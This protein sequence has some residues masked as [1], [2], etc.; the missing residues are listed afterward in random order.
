MMSDYH[1]YLIASLVSSVKNWHKI[2]KLKKISFRQDLQTI[3]LDEFKYGGTNITA[4]RL[5]D[6]NNPSVQ[7][8]VREWS[9]LNKSNKKGEDSIL[10]SITI[11]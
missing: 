7:N 4:F 5:V 6:P 3:N 1:S 2:K 9:V 11:L 10:V 8:A